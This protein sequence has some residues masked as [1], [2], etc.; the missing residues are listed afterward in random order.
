MSRKEGTRG[1]IASIDHSIDAPTRSLEEY[2]KKE[3]RMTNYNDRIHHRCHDDRQN[4]NNKEKEMGRKT[5][6]WI[7]Q[8]TKKR[9]HAREDQVMVT[10]KGNLQMA[11]Q[12]NA[13]RTNYVKTKINKTHENSMCRLCNDR[14][15][16]FDHIIIKCSKQVQ[17]IS[18][19]RHDW[20]EE[21]IN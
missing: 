17:R 14:D 7:L 21:V 11:T 12:N 9:N 6:V 8:A 3:L 18:M 1:G 16:T 13:I 4:D 20:V 5:T 10:I 15:E 19:T 2:T